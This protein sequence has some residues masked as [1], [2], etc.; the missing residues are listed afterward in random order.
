ME[1][2]E[3]TVAEIWNLDKDSSEMRKKNPNQD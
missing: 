1:V 2:C 3:Y